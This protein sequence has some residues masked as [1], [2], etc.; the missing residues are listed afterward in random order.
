M[1]GLR[2]R[3]MSGLRD[4]EIVFDRKSLDFAGLLGGLGDPRAEGFLPQLAVYR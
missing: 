3:P 4:G 1:C 2:W